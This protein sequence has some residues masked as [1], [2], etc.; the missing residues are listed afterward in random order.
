MFG[1]I[2]AHAAA[3]RKNQN[4]R[5]ARKHIKKAE[6]AQVDIAGPVYGTGKANGTGANDM[7]QVIL[8]FNWF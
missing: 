3:G 8:F 1:G 2:V 5:M 6:R 7:L 4:R